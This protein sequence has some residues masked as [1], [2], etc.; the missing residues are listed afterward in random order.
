MSH[1]PSC[2]PFGGA[3][4]R[5]YNW[6]SIQCRA[7]WIA[8]TRTVR[9]QTSH[10][11]ALEVGVSRGGPRS[12]PG[13]VR[14]S[15]P[16]GN[17][18]GACAVLLQRRPRHIPGTGAMNANVKYYRRSCHNVV[19]RCLRVDRFVWWVNSL[20]QVATLECLASACTPILLHC[21]QGV[22]ARRIVPYLT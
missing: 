17:G 15:R 20:S 10:W 14:S 8:E 6:R 9:T 22:P 21:I 19:R 13:V 3:M 7:V 1:N 2:I 4:G 5:E 18:G 11:V 12:N 16:F